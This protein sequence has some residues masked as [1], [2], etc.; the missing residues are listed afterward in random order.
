[1]CST[2][3]IEY[4]FVYVEQRAF[5]FSVF[6]ADGELFRL[7]FWGNHNRPDTKK[8][9]MLL[10]HYLPPKASNTLVLDNDNNRHPRQSFIYNTS[11]PDMLIYSR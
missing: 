10:H 4:Y 6:R 11:L 2:I 3:K 1:M 8:T 7:D 9:W 5:T